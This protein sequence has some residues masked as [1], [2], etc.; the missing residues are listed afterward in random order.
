LSPQLQVCRTES[1]FDNSGDSSTGR[2]QS[3]VWSSVMGFAAV[4]RNR[5]NSCQ[6]YSNVVRRFC[7]LISKITS[8]SSLNVGEVPL[9]N[10]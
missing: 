3:V 7:H 6:D 9:D 1:S 4:W 2:A 5:E 10:T 8:N